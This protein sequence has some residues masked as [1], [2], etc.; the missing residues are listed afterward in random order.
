MSSEAPPALAQSSTTAPR[1]PPTGL[2]LPYLTPQ[3]S[4]TLS[5]GDP[6][7]FVVDVPLQVA[8]QTLLPTAVHRQ[9]S[10][11]TAVDLE[12]NEENF[13][14]MWRT[15]LLKR[16][17]DVHER[18]KH[19]RSANHIRLT[20]QITSPAPLADLAYSLGSYFRAPTGVNYHLTPPQ[21]AAPEPFW[22]VDNQ[23]VA[24]WIRTCKR[25]QKLYVMREFPLASD[26]ENKPLVLTTSNVQAGFVTVK[27]KI[28][29]TEMSDGL[30]SAVNDPLFPNN[31]FPFNNSHITLLH[32][33][34]QAV[35]VA[36][37]TGSY[38]LDANV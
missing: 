23:I 20:S 21:A 18:T 11:L 7:Y 6:D 19:V 28:N 5:R 27:T 4:L 36:D 25:F 8:P 15:L 34:N 2:N 13:I 32:S 26:F 38:V 14:R 29:T 31:H 22:A 24:Q 16:T 10:Q 9:L 35:L 33:K 37:Y 12:I 3:R 30:I 17:Q 1:P